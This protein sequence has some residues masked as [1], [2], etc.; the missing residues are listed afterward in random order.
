MKRVLLSSTLLLVGL[1]G[2]ASTERFYGGIYQGLQTREEL[3]N[4]RPAGGIRR[5]RP[6]SHEEYEVERNRILNEGTAK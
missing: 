2:C 5:D 6:L 3:V 4:T 1:A